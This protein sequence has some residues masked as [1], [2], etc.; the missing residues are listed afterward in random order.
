MTSVV[1]L[2]HGDYMPKISLLHYSKL[3]KSSD[4]SE[5]IN[6]TL[7]ELWAINFFGPRHQAKCDHWLSL[8]P[9]TRL[10]VGKCFRH[11]LWFHGIWPCLW[12]LSRDLDPARGV[13]ISKDLALLLENIKRFGLC[14]WGLTRAYEHFMWT[15][16]P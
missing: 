15:L 14:L 10:S 8:G 12:G 5:F 1:H 7:I 16:D 2:N 9:L 6:V 11:I 3:S 4:S 13:F